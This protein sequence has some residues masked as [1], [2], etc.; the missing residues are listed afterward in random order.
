[1]GKRSSFYQGKASEM[2]DLARRAS[3]L[4]LRDKLEEVAKEYDRLAS[5]DEQQ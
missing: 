4:K 2:R 1:M 3:D 5:E